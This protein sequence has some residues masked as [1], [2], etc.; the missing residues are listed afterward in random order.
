ML[1]DREIVAYFNTGNFPVTEEYLPA[2]F[3]GEQEMAYLYNSSKDFEKRRVYFKS[4]WRAPRVRVPWY[5]YKLMHFGLFYNLE[6]R[7]AVYARF[8]E[9]PAVKL[10][11]HWLRLMSIGVQLS[12]KQSVPLYMVVAVMYARGGEVRWCPGVILEVSKDVIVWCKSGRRIWRYSR[13]TPGAHNMIE[14][15]S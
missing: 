4:E 1:Q 10:F 6:F 3:E 13:A 14:V 12:D 5:M 2:Q 11:T 9:L 8:P 7:S 15:V